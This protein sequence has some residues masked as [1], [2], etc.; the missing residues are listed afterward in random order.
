MKENN[1]RSVLSARRRHLL[2]AMEASY[3][4]LK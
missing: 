2:R 4:Q 1:G 3:G